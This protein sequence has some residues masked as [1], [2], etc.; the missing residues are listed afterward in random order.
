MAKATE[1]SDR[2]AARP[3]GRPG[4]GR[5][6]RPSDRMPRATLRVIWQAE[7]G[8]CESCGRPMDRRCAQASR[9]DPLGGW[10]PDN[11]AVLCC[12]CE[13]RQAGRLRNIAVAPAVLA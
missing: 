5:R 2:R 7:D 4:P 11:L 13:S 10:A 1:I 8:R 12:D 9:R 6:L 3:A